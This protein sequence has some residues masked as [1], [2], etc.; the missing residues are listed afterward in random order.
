MTKILHRR[1]WMLPAVVLAWAS[2]M[3]AGCD[4]S[5]PIAKRIVAKTADLQRTFGGET[6]ETSYH[7]IA[8]D[9]SWLNV[10]VGWYTIVKVGDTITHDHWRNR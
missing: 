9:G 6:N 3:L 2:A 4:S 8:E 10:T 7:L 1:K 5:P